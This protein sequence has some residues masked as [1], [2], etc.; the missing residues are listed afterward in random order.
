MYRKIVLPMCAAAII[1]I[2]ACG[3]SSHLPEGK[4]SIVS[5][6]FDPDLDEKE[7]AKIYESLPELNVEGK[8]TIRVAGD[9][10]FGYF[11][12]EVYRY[13]LGGGIMRF[14]GRNSDIEARF[15][16]FNMDGNKFYLHLNNGY[17]NSILFS[18][19]QRDDK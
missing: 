9:F 15:E 8:R 5:I 10:P 19:E 1:S 16:R 6:S 3:S 11:E 4:Y 18:H 2:A 17:V 7:Y 12:E 13:R 14:E